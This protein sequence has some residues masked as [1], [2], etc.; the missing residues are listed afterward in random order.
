MSRT[1][2]T[3][4][5]VSL[6]ADEVYVKMNV[7]NATDHHDKPTLTVKSITVHPLYNFN[8]PTH[9]LAIIELNDAVAITDTLVPLCLPT[10]LLDTTSQ[11]YV[12]GYG[13]PINVV[14]T[15]LK[16]TNI[17]TFVD[18]TMY[19][20]LPQQTACTDAIACYGD[21]GGP[22][23][24]HDG[25]DQYQLIGLVNSGKTECTQYTIFVNITSN[26]N[27]IYSVIIN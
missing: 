3:L 1:G 21:S 15:H 11:C 5:F 27:W 17:T 8:S 23:A 14:N 18:C 22:L 2:S 20:P 12:T 25:H 19:T 13:S 16:Y 24:C 9:E 26:I 6:H 10:M 4:P 7:S